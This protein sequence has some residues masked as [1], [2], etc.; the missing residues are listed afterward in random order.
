MMVMGTGPAHANGWGFG[1][2]D[3]CA[4]VYLGLY[5]Q[6]IVWAQT[7]VYFALLITSIVNMLPW[8]VGRWLAAGY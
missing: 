7:K 4:W 5:V 3:G 1:V 2:H 6:K 8:S